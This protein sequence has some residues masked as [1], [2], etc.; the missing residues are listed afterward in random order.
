VVTR[1]GKRG[2]IDKAGKELTPFK[3]DYAFS[4][5]EYSEGLAQVKLNEKVGY[6]DRSGKEVIPLK[7]DSVERFIEGYALVNFKG[8]DGYIGRDGTEYFEN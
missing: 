1:N 2:Y 7:Y 3:Y 6:I 4:F 5:S 8:K